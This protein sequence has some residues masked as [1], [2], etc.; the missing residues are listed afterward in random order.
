MKPP[1]DASNI[2]NIIIANRSKASTTDLG[3]RG[4]EFVSDIWKKNSPENNLKKACEF[5]DTDFG[6]ICKKTLR[7]VSYAAI[8]WKPK[9]INLFVIVLLILFLCFIKNICII[10]D[11]PQAIILPTYTSY[12][13]TSNTRSISA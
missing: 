7:D 5:V 8:T 2:L 13:L 10:F 9:N 3:A 1:F 4:A 6:K 11:I 12:I